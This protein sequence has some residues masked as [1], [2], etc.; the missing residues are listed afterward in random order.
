MSEKPRASWDNALDLLVQWHE[1]RR[2]KVGR[3]V[4]RFIES[5]LRLMT[6]A[7]VRRSW[8][9]DLVEDALQDFLVRLVEHR[10]PSD[11]ADLR[12]YLRRAF[13]N[14]CIDSY[15]A[16]A[17]KRET[18][19]ESSAVDWERPQEPAASPLDAVLRDEQRA[20]VQAALVRL[21]LADRVVLKL[22][23][24][25]EW[26]EE[27]EVAWLAERTASSRREIREAIDVADD[28]YAL[29]RI[30]DPGD[31]DPDDPE[32]RR[33]RMERF[34]RRRARAREKLRALLE[35]DGA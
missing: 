4:L 5:E 2:P 6:P 7:L 23:L 25:P 8:P 15:R 18:S 28:M 34:R 32:A 1:E 11:I 31:D 33:M 35:E 24:A 26:L 22:E 20:R 10:L 29:T 9:D 3:A 21:S 27:E 30:F 14:H 13:G 19:L 17:R 16:R 12:A